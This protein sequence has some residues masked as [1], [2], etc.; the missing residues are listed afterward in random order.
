MKELIS[1]DTVTCF[2]SFVISFVCSLFYNNPDLILGKDF[3]K[4]V[5]QSVSYIHT[6]T[7]LFRCGVHP[8]SEKGPPFYL[9]NQTRYP[10]ED[11]IFSCGMAFNGTISDVSYILWLKNNEAVVN[12]TNH[13]ITWEVA[14]Y[15]DGQ[16]VVTTN[17]SIYSVTADDFGMY[18]C[19]VTVLESVT[20]TNDTKQKPTPKPNRRSENVDCSCKCVN[21]PSLRMPEFSKEDIALVYYK[22]HKHH[23]VGEYH[24]L[25]EKHRTRTLFIVPGTLVSVAVY[26]RHLRE[27]DD[28]S[29]RF[30]RSGQDIQSFD[31]QCSYSARANAWLIHL[32]GISVAYNNITYMNATA[33]HWKGSVGIIWT[34]IS[35]SMYVFTAAWQS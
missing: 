13:Y 21:S 2:V 26:F 14:N 24:L 30:T 28:F 35:P 29:V 15:S 27:I 1:R 7:T 10:G 33:G 11:A 31:T 25:Q 20:P 19:Y 32:N 23:W 34:C 6:S 8:I 16:V 4:M 5:K 22:L 3:V 18:Q 9:V 12:E 17:L